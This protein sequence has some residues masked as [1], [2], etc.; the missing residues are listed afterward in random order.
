[1]KRME[2]GLTEIESECSSWKIRL[3]SE[4]DWINSL[5]Q[6]T[7]HAARRRKPQDFV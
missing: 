3:N 4:K 2:H 5:F 1:V 6:V 7:H